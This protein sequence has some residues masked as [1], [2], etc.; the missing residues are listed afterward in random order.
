MKKKINQL[1]LLNGGFGTRVK[2]ISKKKPKCLIKFKKK[3]FLYWQLNMFKKNGIKEVI[4]CTGYKNKYIVKELKN[5]NIKNINIKIINEKQPLGTGGAIKNC[6]KLLNNFFYVTYG[7]S[8]LNFRFHDLKRKFINK[9]AKN[10][11]TVI[12]KKKA[13]D[14]LPN[15][16]IKKNKIIDYSK[17]NENYNYIDYGLMIFNKIEFTITKKKKFDLSFLI[18]RVIHQKSTYYYKVTRKFYEIGS[19]KGIKEFKKIIK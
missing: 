15:I 18:N 7:D 4:I 10:I 9:N 8:W 3:S 19:L 11:I 1:V 17:N 5:L 6:S 2:S 16:L 13:I 14:H 12:N